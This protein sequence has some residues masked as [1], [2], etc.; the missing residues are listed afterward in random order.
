MGKCI[1]LIAA[2]LMGM[3]QLSAERERLHRSPSRLLRN[4]LSI[5]GTA[6]TNADESGEETNAFDHGK[7]YE[8]RTLTEENLNEV[9]ALLDE[10]FPNEFDNAFGKALSDGKYNSVLLY[11]KDSN[12]IVGVSTWHIQKESSVPTG[13]IT[14][15]GIRKSIRKQGL[16]KYLMDGTL[17]R[18]KQ[19][20]CEQVQLHVLATNEPA[21]RFYRKYGFA[22]K[23]LKMGQFVYG[24]E[25]T[26]PYKDIEFDC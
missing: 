6:E 2:I 4:L 11:A 19:R 13:F 16:G 8:F 15:F 10:L 20:G 21:I 24:F 14:T 18:I 25:G 17:A 9:H 7:N 5:D 23:E 22:L 26:R 12:V 1:S 3:S